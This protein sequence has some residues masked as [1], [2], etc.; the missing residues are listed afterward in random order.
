M[1]SITAVCQPDP[2][3]G[4]G[5][6]RRERT[7]RGALLALFLLAGCGGGPTFTA[8]EFVDRINEEG[9]AVQLG[10][11]LPSGG[12]AEHIYT[13]ILPPLPGEP[14]PAPGT[15]ARPGT[16][17]SLYVYDDTGGAEDE[18]TACR[19]AATLLCFQAANVVVVLEGGGIEAQRL[20]LA[21]RKLA[22]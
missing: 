21:I 16:S 1:R 13:V 2:A 4:R 6:A 20:G 12:G 5:P 22:E 18:L 17:G 7:L 11:Q 8:A 10:R 3:L 9:V 19:S 14:A 15:E